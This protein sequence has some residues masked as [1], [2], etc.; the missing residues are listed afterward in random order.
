ML[1]N[2]ERSIVLLFCRMRKLLRIR[3]FANILFRQAHWIWTRDLNS[4]QINTIRFATMRS[5]YSRP[6]LVLLVQTLA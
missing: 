3:S 4:L 5:L 2:F 1:T 6:V